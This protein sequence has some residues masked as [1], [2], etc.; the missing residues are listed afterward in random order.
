M[1]RRGT[2]GTGQGEQHRQPARGPGNSSG[3]PWLRESLGT[4]GGEWTWLALVHPL[5]PGGDEAPAAGGGRCSRCTGAGQA[6]RTLAARTL[7]ACAG[8]SPEEEGSNTGQSRE[9]P[10]AGQSSPCPPGCVAVPLSHRSDHAACAP[11]A[12]PPPDACGRRSPHLASTAGEYRIFHIWLS[13]IA[14]LGQ[15]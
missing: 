15:S 10:G 3:S 12:D 11:S 7:A 8:A 1:V 14:S 4:A 6:A 13:M 5:K 2:L 9:C